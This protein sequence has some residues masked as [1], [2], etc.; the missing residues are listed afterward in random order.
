MVI[1]G[2][3]YSSLRF[4]IGLFRLRWQGGASLRF[5]SPL[6]ELRCRRNTQ[7]DF[8]LSQKIPKDKISVFRNLVSRNTRAN[9]LHQG[10][11][12]VEDLRLPTGTTGGANRVMVRWWA[13]PPNHRKDE[14]VMGSFKEWYMYLYWKLD[15]Y[16]IFKHGRADRWRKHQI[17]PPL[18]HG[19]CKCI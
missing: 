16:L 2:M 19:I 8:W 14:P 7:D 6:I 10:Y 1:T 15:N 11:F 13:K 4:D 5:L 9:A 12:L 18:K 17:T 3:D